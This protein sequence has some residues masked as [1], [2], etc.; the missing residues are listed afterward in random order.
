MDTENPQ[1]G[2]VIL[3]P[4]ILFVG[5]KPGY[6]VLLAMSDD[7]ATLGFVDILEAGIAPTG[8]TINMPRDALGRFHPTSHKLDVSGFPYG[9]PPAETIIQE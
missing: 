3:M 8:R 7:K 2:D 5:V 4:E 6:Y 9:W 1:L